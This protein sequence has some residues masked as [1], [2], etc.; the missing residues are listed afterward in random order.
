MHLKN[1][2]NFSRQTCSTV[3]YRPR[4]A[5][6][7]SLSEG[8]VPYSPGDARWRSLYVASMNK[9]GITAKQKRMLDPTMETFLDFRNSPDP[10]ATSDS[11]E[12]P[13]KV[14]CDNEC[15]DCY[16][17]DWGGGVSTMLTMYYFLVASYTGQPHL[18]TTNQSIINARRMRTRVIVV[19][20]L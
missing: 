18:L 3:F 7:T 5:L 12:D 15:V 13:E 11:S 2:H 8:E 17:L 14:L 9:A 19:F 20:C 1:G 4:L 16:V 6:G 10:S